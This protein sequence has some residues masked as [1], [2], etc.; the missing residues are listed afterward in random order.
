MIYRMRVL[1]LVAFAFLT[2]TLA[3]SQAVLQ[4]SSELPAEF[5]NDRSEVRPWVIE[6]KAYLL[7]QKVDCYEF[8]DALGQQIFSQL[9][10]SRFFLTFRIICS[11]D[12]D[13]TRID[14]AIS[15]EALDNQYVAEAEGIAKIINGTN[16]LSYKPV[17]KRAHDIFTVISLRTLLTEVGSSPRLI[18]ELDGELRHKSLADLVSVIDKKLEAVRSPFPLDI[19]QWMSNSLG[20]DVSPILM[21]DVFPL[22]NLL[23]IDLNANFLFEDGTHSSVQSHYPTR[24]SRDCSKSDTSRC[25]GKIPVL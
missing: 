25:D 12:A 1:F 3:Y 16:V 20:R 22:G 17:A 24:S 9:P 18:N 15:F 23:R 10:D 11:L 2:S 6:S 4:G 8:F 7:D 14:A 19:A 21:N 5:T 13:P